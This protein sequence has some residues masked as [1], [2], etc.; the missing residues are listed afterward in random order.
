MEPKMKY[1]TIKFSKLF[2]LKI[3]RI[4][5]KFHPMVAQLSPIHYYDSIKLLDPTTIRQKGFQKQFI[6]VQS[7]NFGLQ[8]WLH[9]V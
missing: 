2:I 9:L 8:F 5:E 4:S 6:S 1:A 7:S 3:F